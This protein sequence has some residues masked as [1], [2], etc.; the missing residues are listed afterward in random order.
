MTKD[1]YNP[2]LLAAL[3]NHTNVVRILLSRK[4]LTNETVNV[5]EP[6]VS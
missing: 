1:G 6:K 5:Q 3:N 2:L 4:I